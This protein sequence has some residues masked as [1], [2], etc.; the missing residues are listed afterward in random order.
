M[1]KIVVFN[2][3]VQNML[4]KLL[5]KENTPADMLEKQFDKFLDGW[6][7]LEIA[8]G[9]YLEAAEKEDDEY[10]KDPEKAMEAGYSQSNDRL[11]DLRNKEQE[12]KDTAVATERTEAEENRKRI[13]AV[14]VETEKAKFLEDAESFRG[15]AK[16]LENKVGTEIGAADKRREGLVLIR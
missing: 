8:H 14:K 2:R 13:A 16:I 12:K 4:L 11:I 15:L 3:L 1:V 6:N 9:D 10:L 7:K 5:E